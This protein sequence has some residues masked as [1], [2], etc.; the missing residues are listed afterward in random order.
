VLVLE[1]N[2]EIGGATASVRTFPEF[3]ARLS[4][5]SYLIS[6]LPDQILND[7]GLNI[8]CLSRKVSS[9]TPLNFHGVDSGLYVAR[10][11]DKKTETSFLELP[12][13]KND[14]IAW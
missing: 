3:D 13:G 9:Y 4:R 5:Y 8:K 6:L 2:S 14:I 12:H 1:A 10:A 7:L 11:W